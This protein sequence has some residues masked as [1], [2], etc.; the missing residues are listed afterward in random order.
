MIPGIYQG[1]SA[2]NALE[3]WQTAITSNLASGSVAGF[4]KDDT[5]F[6]SALAGSTRLVPGEASAEIKQYTPQAT[7]RITDTQGR[8]QAAWRFG[9]TSAR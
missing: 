7:T 2:M 6:S 5:S 8:F 3:R 4:K 1:A 9:W